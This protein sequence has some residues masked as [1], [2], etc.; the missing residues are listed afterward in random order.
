VVILDNLSSHKNSAAAAALRDRG[1]WFLFLSP[2]SPDLIPIEMAV[3]QAQGADQKS[4]RP[5]LRSAPG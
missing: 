2:C 1:A 5:H 4:R 3:L